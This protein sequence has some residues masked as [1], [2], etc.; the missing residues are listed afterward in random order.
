MLSQLARNIR[1]LRQ[2]RRMTQAQLANMLHVTP[3]AVSKWER[4]VALPDIQMVL[5]IAMNFGVSTD[6]LLFKKIL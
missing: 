5:L 1:N 3:Q 2:E 6:D 4:G